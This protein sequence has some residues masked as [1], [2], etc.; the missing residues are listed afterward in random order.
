[1]SEL[2]EY[3]YTCYEDDCGFMCHLLMKAGVKLATVGN[4]L[5]LLNKNNFVL[6]EVTVSYAETAAKD[7]EG[8]NISAYLISAGASGN[9]LVVTNGAGTD[10]AITIPYATKAEYDTEN[11]KL[12]S[13]LRNF[14]LDG[15]QVKVTLGDGSSYNL[16]IPFAT[17]A[18]TDV[19]GKTLTSYAA[20]LI[21]DGNK[22]VLKNGNGNTINEITVPYATNAGTADVAE[23]AENDLNGNAILSNYAGSLK[24]NAS[25]IELDAKDGTKLSEITVPFATLATDA[26]NAV[27]TVQIVGN[28]IVFTT[29]GGTIVR[30]TIPYSLKA[31]GDKEGNDITETY[32][33]N[34][35]QDPV[36]G[37]INFY[38]KDGSTICSLTPSARVAEYDTYDNLIADYIKT[39]IFDNQSDYLVATH[40]DGTVDSIVINY[41]NTA[42]KDTQ[43]NIIKNTYVKS[44]SNEVDGNGDYV[45]IAYNGSNQEIFRFVLNAN[46]A[47]NDSLGN[48]ISKTYI[49]DLT[50]DEANN[51]LVAEAGDGSTADEVQIYPFS[52]QVYAKANKADGDNTNYPNDDSNVTHGTA[53]T[54]MVDQNNNEFGTKQYFNNIKLKTSVNYEN[55]RN[56]FVSNH[57]VEELSVIRPEAYLTVKGNEWSN[58]VELVFSNP[59]VRTLAIDEEWYN[60]WYDGTNNTYG[61]PNAIQGAVAVKTEYDILNAVKA[62]PF[63]KPTIN[64][65]ADSAYT[66]AAGSTATIRLNCGLYSLQTRNMS[67]FVLEDDANKFEVGIEDLFTKG[68]KYYKDYNNKIVAIDVVVENIGTSPIS[69]AQDDAVPVKIDN[70]FIGEPYSDRV[71]VVKDFGTYTDFDQVVDNTIR[72]DIAY[73]ANIFAFGNVFKTQFAENAMVLNCKF[74]RIC[75]YRANNSYAREGLNAGTIIMDSNQENEVFRVDTISD[76]G[77]SVT[78]ESAN[79]DINYFADGDVIVFF[80]DAGK[81]IATIVKK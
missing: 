45:L 50:Y 4:K 11:Q 46:S 13:Y 52:R 33:A 23:K 26:T 53:Q 16:T 21:V 69:I 5:Q 81:A 14:T 68:Y 59:V 27:E 72:I 64:F 7:T 38:A 20:S 55:V 35:V 8:N 54:L 61:T 47:K 43:G 28:E 65:A 78:Y 74:N 3:P 9:T 24:A 17:I 42:W 29:Y 1:M 51:K 77:I 32:V 49:A 79:D 10:Y 41:S 58:D 37:E 62:I 30:C 25:T 73:L 56:T 12:T 57:R 15:N 63:E 22:L 75:V 19:A 34:V 71:Q 36:T 66:I 70:D 60:N 6:S 39:L 31:L 80:S 40:G 67:T 18:R 48:N 44:M 2:H 76:T